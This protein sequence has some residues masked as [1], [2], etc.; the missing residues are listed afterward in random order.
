MVTPLPTMVDGDPEGDDV[1]MAF[2]D[3]A[4][5]TSEDLDILRTAFPDRNNLGKSYFSA[6]SLVAVAS[7][8]DSPVEKQAKQ[9]LSW[10][11]SQVQ[12][13]TSSAWEV[14]RESAFTN[15][16]T[17]LTCLKTELAHDGKDKW[18]IHVGTDL[19][20]FQIIA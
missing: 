18:K 1:F 4:A 16:L 15:T 11:L 5:V 14:L 12:P 2:P 17:K 13:Y 20:N 6:F 10:A 3:N 8:C 19:G 9:I 7:A